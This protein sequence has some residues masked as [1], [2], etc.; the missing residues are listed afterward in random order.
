MGYKSRE[1][2]RKYRAEQNAVAKSK[3]LHEKATGRRWFLTLVRRDC[4]CAWCG[5]VLRRGGEMVYR[6]R[7]RENRCVRCADADPESKGYRTSRKW[8]KE[9]DRRRR[10]AV[11]APAAAGPPKAVCPAGG[12]R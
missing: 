3:R 8:A 6:H 12:R 1:K 11:R 5:R 4:A 2:K 10:T 9:N 7:P